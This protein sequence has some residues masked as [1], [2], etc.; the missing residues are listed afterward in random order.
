MIN[1]YSGDIEEETIDNTDYRRTL[2]T[3][4]MQLVVM[5]LTPEEDIPEEVHPNIDQFIRVE[6]GKARVRIE[7]EEHVLESDDVI[8]IPSGKKHYVNNISEDQDLKLYT[9]YTPPEHPENTVHEDQ[10]EAEEAE[11]H[12]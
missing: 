8:I 10:E 12:H 9:I 7:D 2:Y 11:H 1:T 6:E 3:G 5:S 4:R